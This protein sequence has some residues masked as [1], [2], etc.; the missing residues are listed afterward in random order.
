MNWLVSM[1]GTWRRQIRQRNVLVE[2]PLSGFVMITIHV[3]EIPDVY[4]DGELLPP[5]MGISV[6]P[7]PRPQIDFLRVLYPPH[8]IIAGDQFATW[9]TKL[10]CRNGMPWKY[11]R[12]CRLVGQDIRVEYEGRVLHFRA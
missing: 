10:V 3:E 8:T 9:L 6:E 11:I 5:Y 12:V 4:V 7:V 2:K 1:R